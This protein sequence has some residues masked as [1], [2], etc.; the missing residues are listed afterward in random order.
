[1]A[2][3]A[4][5]CGLLRRASADWKSALEVTAWL[6]RMD[7]GDPVR[8]DYALCR[9]GILGTCPRRRQARK[10]TACPLFDVCLL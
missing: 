1:V 4:R 3:I 6:R 10:C 9:L 7:A 2:R 5:Y 8:Y